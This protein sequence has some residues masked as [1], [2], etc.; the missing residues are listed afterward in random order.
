MRRKI[1]LSMDLV[2]KLSTNDKNGLL[3]VHSLLGSYDDT[4]PS[5]PVLMKNHGHAFVSHSIAPLFATRCAI[6][7]LCRY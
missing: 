5:D 3:F 1:V 4:V 2:W 7:F 6:E